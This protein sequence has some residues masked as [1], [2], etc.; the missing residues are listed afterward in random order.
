[1]TLALPEPTSSRN[2]WPRLSGDQAYSNEAYG[3]DWFVCA[4]IFADEPSK[5][6]LHITSPIDTLINTSATISVRRS[7]GAVIRHAKYDSCRAHRNVTSG[8]YILVGAAVNDQL[9]CIWRRAAVA[10]PGCRTAP[11]KEVCN[12]PR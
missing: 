1:M 5:L 3:P 6:T 12:A 11:Q 10:Q 7:D 2:Y 9:P 4:A 8:A